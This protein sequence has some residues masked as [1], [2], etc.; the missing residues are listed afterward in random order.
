MIDVYKILKRIEERPS[1]YLVSP[2]ITNLKVFLNGYYCARSDIGSLPMEGEHDF[3]E[4]QNWIQKKF[5][6]CSSQSWAK[7][8]LFYSIDER[9]ALDKFFKL[10]EEFQHRNGYLESAKNLDG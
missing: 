9:D 2:S 6:I 5:R 8:I 7:I 1:M 4:F 10:F 3:E